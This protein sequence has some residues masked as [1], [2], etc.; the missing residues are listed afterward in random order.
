MLRALL[1]S[2]ALTRLVNFPVCTWLIWCRRHQLPQNVLYGH[3][4][5]AA[6]GIALNAGWFAQLTRIARRELSSRR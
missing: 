4:G 5:F 3:L 6:A 1:A 2:F